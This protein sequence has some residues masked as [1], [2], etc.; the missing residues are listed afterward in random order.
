[1]RKL[2]LSRKRKTRNLADG[3]GIHHD[4][5]V[6]LDLAEEQ[7]HDL[8]VRILTGDL[9]ASL[10]CVQNLFQRKSNQ[11]PTGEGATRTRN[12]KVDD[13]E[14]DSK[15]ASRRPENKIAPFSKAQCPRS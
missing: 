1:M 5:G 15:A 8:V 12:K 14:R 4:Q 6:A 7:A 2:P 10:A 3:E 11:E 13:V 9:R